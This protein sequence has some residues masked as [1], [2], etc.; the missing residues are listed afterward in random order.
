[1]YEI[2][3]NFDITQYLNHMLSILKCDESDR[4]IFT[5]ALHYAAKL[6]KDQKRRS[7]EPY[8]VHPCSVA[9]IILCELE[10]H[11]AKLLSAALLHDVL[12]DVK[13]Q[14]PKHISER[15]GKRVAEIVDG[16][17]KLRLYR[18]SR[19]D[20]ADLTHMKIFRRAAKHMG[21]FIVKLADRLHN[22]RTL[23]Y[24]PSANRQRI[25]RET[26]EIYIPIAAILNM[27]ALKQ[28]LCDQSLYYLF[29]KKCR[30]ISNFIQSELDLN[31]LNEIKRVIQTALQNEN[32]DAT[33]RIVPKGLGDY[34]DPVRKTMNKSHS[35]NHVDFI[36][37]I[38]N[39][40]KK[41]DCYLAMGIINSIY[42]PIPR[43]LRD[44]IAN[45]KSNGYRSLHI[46]YNIAGKNYLFLIRTQ[47]MD[48]IAMRGILANWTNNGF[49]ITDDHWNH[50][51]EQ[52]QI[53]GEY[54]G[55]AI[56]RREMIQVSGTKEIYL[57]TP[58]GRV[59]CLPAGSIVLDFAHKIHTDIGRTC[60]GAIVNNRKLSID[61]PLNDGDIVH[62]L[63]QNKTL[64]LHHKLE[65]ICRTAKAR[66]DINRD[67]NQKLKNF[68][69]KIGQII[70]SQIM[71]RHQLDPNF[72]SYSHNSWIFD[73]VTANNLKEAY[74]Q[75]GQDK[76]PPHLF[77]FYTLP[78]DD[79]Q[80]HFNQANKS[81]PHLADITID[82]EDFMFYKF[83]QCCCPYPG[84]DNLIGLLS[85]RG[86]SF[87]HQSC[88]EIT[89]LKIK[90]EKWLKV[91]WPDVKWPAM[92]FQ[93]DI[94]EKNLLEVM[95][96]L[97]YLDP[98]IQI[99]SL[100]ENHKGNKCYT[101]V[102]V[103]LTSLEES[104]KFF[105]GL[106]EGAFTINDINWYSPNDCYH[107]LK[108]ERE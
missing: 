106:P 69:E 107:I 41:Y 35:E 37:I 87:H 43:K 104:K 28:K 84:Q 33:I 14:K 57:F 50:I 44:F 46:R 8:I 83:S 73:L 71:N 16:C 48:E 74:R 94:K 82:V 98:K 70:L 51:R 29:P 86:I 54:D 31:E 85:E 77:L 17:T 56:Q 45:P 19:K 11:D 2:Q 91:H 95:K 25:A 5:D 21:I 42:P 3:K 53:I 6:H 30:Q 92:F 13:G 26:M 78:T 76:L 40:N 27:Y 23:H 32:I 34:Y 81:T 108:Q 63:T 102:N 59:V 15:F 65:K 89:R 64:Q 7:G 67:Y 100:K 36:I 101:T 10:L 55:A 72:F 88:E 99:L 61:E 60:I 90:S 38:N 12:E 58:K 79:L 52:F 18:M 1:M 9:E 4:Q 47:K 24:L 68:S 49:N 22:L 75:I 39:P 80:K 105:S 20:L 93:I 103:V 97:A 96:Q 62:I 66:M